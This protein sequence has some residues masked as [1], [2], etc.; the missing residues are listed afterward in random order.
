MAAA[1]RAGARPPAIEP[2]RVFKASSGRRIEYAVAGAGD[3][4]PVLMFYPMGASCRLAD[5]FDWPAKQANAR[6]ICVNR[7]GRGWTSPAPSHAGSHLQ[8]A[9]EDAQACLDH[10]HLSRAAV[11]FLCAG[12]P[13]ALAFCAR[14]PHRTNGKVVGCSSWVSPSD[15][16]AAR[17]LY[18]LGASMPVGVLAAAAGAMA[19]CLQSVAL[20]SFSSD[21]QAQGGGVTHEE[22]EVLCSER[23]AE[24]QDRVALILEK[25]Q[26]ETGGEGED[27]A[28]LVD[29]AQAWGLS[30]KTL[31]HSVSLFHGEDDATVPIACAEWL[32]DQLPPSS[33]LYRIP[34]GTHSGVMLLGIQLAL[35]TLL[36]D[37]WGTGFPVCCFTGHGPWDRIASV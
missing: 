31:G 29:S 9:C 17:L 22:A 13:F 1:P 14:F 26:S 21:V 33:V 23:T 18:K 6:L 20:G 19:H 3:G 5:L 16:P 30:Y 36:M 4:E 24:C 8:T 10:L 7:P 25:L 11:L 2:A 37:D 34:R 28:V 32:R 15:C 35:R 27:S 12:A